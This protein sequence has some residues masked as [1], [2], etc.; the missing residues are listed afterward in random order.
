MSQLRSSPKMGR[1]A[2][3]CNQKTSSSSQTPSSPY[4]QTKFDHQQYV[5]TVIAIEHD[6]YAYSSQQSPTAFGG[7]KGLDRV[8]L[9]RNI[10]KL[11]ERKETPTTSPIHDI[12]R[13]PQ[14]NRLLHQDRSREPLDLTDVAVNFEHLE[15]FENSPKLQE[16]CAL[17]IYEVSRLDD[18]TPIN[19]EL[20]DISEMSLQHDEP[21]QP[22]GEFLTFFNSLR[23]L[24]NLNLIYYFN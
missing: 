22:I 5:E 4:H 15:S 23:L 16:I 12:T 6:Q 14:F 11:L 24:I 8:I 9:E 20:P 19:E 10:E 7:G 2:L 17:P 1:R 21:S 18:I 13:S 3:Q